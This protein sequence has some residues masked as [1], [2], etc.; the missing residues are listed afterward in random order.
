MD[1]PVTVTAILPVW[2]GAEYIEETIRSIQAQTFSDWEMFIMGEPDGPGIFKEIALRYSA[3]DKRIRWIENETHLGLAATLNKGI[4]LAQGKYIARVDADDP[5]YPIRFEKQARY[6]EEHPAVGILGSQCRKIYSI[7]C[8]ITAYP[9]RSEDIAA[10]MLFFCANCHSSLMLRRKLFMKNNWRYPVNQ[11]QEDYALWLSLLNE[12]IFVNLEEVL[13]DR[14]FDLDIGISARKKREIADASNNLFAAAVKKYFHIDIKKYTRYR[15]LSVYNYHL[16]ILIA[17]NC[18]SIYELAEW[19]IDTVRLYIDMEAANHKH[20]VFENAAFARALSKHWN[21]ILD[22]LLIF[23][24]V[25]SFACGLSHLKENTSRSFNEELRDT[26]LNNDVDGRLVLDIAANYANSYVKKVGA[27][28][29]SKPRVVI[30]GTGYYCREFFEEIGNHEELFEIIA[31]CDNDKNKLGETI[32]GQLILAPDSL[33][34]LAYDYI[35][36]ATHDYYN[37]VYAQLIGM[38]IPQEK[39]LPLDLFRLSV[40]AQS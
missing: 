26:L 15:F 10:N 39:L 27:I 29:F 9:I 30:F 13:L 16:G 14:H 3:A 22:N 5:A 12:T 32:F 38:G 33:N 4:K 2:T 31:L 34:N 11:P 23:D 20:R 6:L 18:P 25:Y 8:E 1:N 40:G 36:I 19:I 28:I 7:F 21:W 37:D 35:L 17:L 24:G